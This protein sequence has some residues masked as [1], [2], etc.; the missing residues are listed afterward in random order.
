M[1]ALLPRGIRDASQALFDWPLCAKG[2]A[3]LATHDVFWNRMCQYGHSCKNAFLRTCSRA[4]VSHCAG[5]NSACGAFSPS[6]QRRV[7]GGQRQQRERL[8]QR[9]VRRSRLRLIF[10]QKTDF[11]VP[12]CLTKVPRIAYGRTVPT[13]AACAAQNVLFIYLFSN[14]CVCVCTLYSARNMRMRCN[15]DRH[16]KSWPYFCSLCCQRTEEGSQIFG[17]PFRISFMVQEY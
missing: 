8:S 2:L 6:Q 14:F 15:G 5:D 17:N 9:R 3:L 7:G 16:A 10:V 12:W 1:C 11:S 4:H 13:C